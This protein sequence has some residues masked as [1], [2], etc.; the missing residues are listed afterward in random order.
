MSYLKKIEQSKYAHKNVSEIW[1]ET[2]QVENIGIDAAKK[3][4][5]ASGWTLDHDPAYYH[6]AYDLRFKKGSEE[7]TVEVKTEPRCGYESVWDTNPSKRRYNTSFVE[8]KDKASRHPQKLTGL[9]LTESD[10]YWFQNAAGSFL[11][12]TNVL[13]TFGYKVPRDKHVHGGINKSSF[14]FKLPVEWLREYKI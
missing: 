9:A 2:R 14:G 13:K 6:P 7:L 11:V 12:P 1:N 3:H 5:K 8:Y 4:F 10:Y